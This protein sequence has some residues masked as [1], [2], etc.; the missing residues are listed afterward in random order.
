MGEITI[1][2]GRFAPTPSGHMHLGNAMTALLVWL[3]MRSCKGT[4]ILRIE[5]LDQARA[6]EAYRTMILEDLQWLGLDF[7]EGPEIGGAFSPYVQSLR[8]DSYERALEKLQNKGL[9]YPCFCSRADLA[10]LGH[11]PH[12]LASEGA[13]YPGTCSALSQSEIAQRRQ[14]KTPSWRF[15]LPITKTVW[16]DGGVGVCHYDANFGGDFIV[17]RADGVIS[18]QLAVVVDDAAMAITDVLRG[19]DLVDST[20]RQLAL[21]E[22]LELPVPRFT[23]VPLVIAHDGQRLAKRDHALSL[24]ALRA[25]KISAEAVIGCLAQICG[26]QPDCTPVKAQDLIPLYNKI[27]FRQNAWRMSEAVV[28]RLSL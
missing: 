22:A 6:K 17:R 19:R 25:K 4:V 15:R 5:D 24:G 18:Y 16:R 3:Q 26:L 11:A 7:D 20:P 23:H 8:S 10:S 2:R 12:G 14:I 13:A 9:L 21:S 27:D 1:R 28:R